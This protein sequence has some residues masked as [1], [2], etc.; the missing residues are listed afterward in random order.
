MLALSIQEFVHSGGMMVSLF[1]VWL[2]C[3]T[4]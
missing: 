4:T 2:V 1:V 3:D